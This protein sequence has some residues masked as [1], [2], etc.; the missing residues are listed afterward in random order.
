LFWKLLTVGELEVVRRRIRRRKIMSKNNSLPNSESVVV[1]LSSS[2]HGMH[3]TW[4]CNAALGF[5]IVW[6][7]LENIPVTFL[8]CHI[9]S[10]P[11]VSAE[12]WMRLP[13]WKWHECRCY[14]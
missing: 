7:A 9:L 13:K 8:Y 1:R 5:H 10:Q 2:P 14:C 12:Y 6:G 4:W 3:Q 11:S